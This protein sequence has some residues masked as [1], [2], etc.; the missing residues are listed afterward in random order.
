MKDQSFR[1]TVETLNIV[2]KTL[3][4]III[5][6]LGQVTLLQCDDKCIQCA[7]NMNSKQMRM[8]NCVLIFLR[9]VIQ[10]SVFGFLSIVCTVFYKY[11]FYTYTCAYAD[12]DRK[13]YVMSVSVSDIKFIKFSLPSS[14]CVHACAF[15]LNLFFAFLSFLFFIRKTLSRKRLNACLVSYFCTK[16]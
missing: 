10:F 4:I 12:V 16:K 11:I 7:H 13:F 14:I 5:R 9:I 15:I 2:C 8:Q 1:I 6:I 3:I